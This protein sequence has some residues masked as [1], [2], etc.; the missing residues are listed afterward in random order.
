MMIK[1]TMMKQ[2]LTILLI[3]AG[4][5]LTSCNDGSKPQSETTQPT[6]SKEN[7]QSKED[8]IVYK[9]DNLIVRKL[10]EHIYQ[11]I[12]FLNSKDFGRVDC[13]GMV[14]ANDNE[15]II[16]DTTCDNESSLELINYVTEELKAKITAVI[17]T[18]F[19]DDCV[20]G[21]EKFNEKQIPSYASDKTI[22]LL[23]NKEN[24]YA[25]SIKGFDDSLTLNVGDMKVSAEYFG[26]GHT[27]DNIIGYVA[28]D[29]TVFGGCLIKEVGAKEGNLGDANVNAWSATVKK[30]K[31]K[32]PQAKIVIPGHG[33]TGGTDLFDYTITLFEQKN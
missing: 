30:L 27:K 17:P 26:E 12:S 8:S 3:M 14:V 21:I 15:A 4:L 28:E 6:I 13:N 5:F 9:T 18:H 25:D 11:H 29:E 22:E 1:T 24:K 16:F 20:G 33:K 7:S 2:S 31:Q 32:Y 10:S 23:K 19:H